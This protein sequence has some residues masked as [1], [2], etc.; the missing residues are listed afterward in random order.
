MAINTSLGDMVTM[1]RNEIGAS[2]NPAQGQNELPILKNIIKR[3]QEMLYDDFDWQHM[4]KDVDMDLF[5]GQRYYT[6]DPEI[7]FDRIKKAYVNWSTS[8]DELP[9]GIDPTYYNYNNSEVAGNRADPALRW[10]HYDTNS[11]EVWP[12]PT[13]NLAQKIRFRCIRNLRPLIADAD[14]SDIDDRLIVLFCASE[15]LARNKAA[16]ASA[17][18]QLAQQRY[19]RLKGH[20]L[21]RDMI[22]L[23]GGIPRT[24]RQDWNI[25]VVGS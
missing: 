9:Y 6:F 25:R 3:T 2:I 15:I 22:I 10:Q 21:K 18:Q 23:G 5:A 12:V 8:W 11:F 19:G 24:R 17:K 20:Q 7:N 14:Q 16:D 4:L 1:L 13:G